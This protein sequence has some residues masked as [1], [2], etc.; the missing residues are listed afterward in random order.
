M[1][2]A[3]VAHVCHVNRVPFIAV[4]TITDTATHNGMEN[5]DKNCETA[6][7]I[8]AEVVIGMLAELER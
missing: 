6:S 8:S 7:R 2:T 1:E 3:S 4:R 5:Y